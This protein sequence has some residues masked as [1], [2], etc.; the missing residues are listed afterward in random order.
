MNKMLSAEKE[1][2][3]NWTELMELA[4]KARH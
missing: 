2:I 3:D 4:K 1:I